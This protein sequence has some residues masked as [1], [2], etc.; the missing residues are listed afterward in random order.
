M[1][2]LLNSL[3]VLMILFNPLTVLVPVLVVLKIQHTVLQEI[4]LF[5]RSLMINTRPLIGCLEN[6]DLKSNNYS[7]FVA[8]CFKTSCSLFSDTMSYMYTLYANVSGSA[9]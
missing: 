1:V 4:L 7:V 8:D 6:S 9:T 2:I 3:P 5:T